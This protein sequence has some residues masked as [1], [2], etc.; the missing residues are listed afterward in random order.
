MTNYSRGADFERKVM[1]DL[2]ERGFECIRSAGS[3]G[4]VDVMAFKTGEHWAVQ[5][6]INGRISPAERKKL[7]AFAHI[8]SMKAIKAW[9]P[10]R[11]E[12]R[13]D[14]VGVR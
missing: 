9:R 6:K 5:C 2:A 7:L 1:T 4:A 8:G 13:Y 12:I 14:E 11:G 10:K 3:H